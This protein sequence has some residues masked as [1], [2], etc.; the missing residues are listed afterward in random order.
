MFIF[1]KFSILFIAFAICECVDVLTN[2]NAQISLSSGPPS[3]GQLSF[4]HYSMPPGFNF[5]NGLGGHHGNPDEQ[6]GNHGEYQGGPG[7]PNINFLKNVSSEARME[8]L[9]IVKN[10]NLTKNDIETQLQA[11]SVQQSPEVQVNF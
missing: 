4:Q 3:S 11:W 2:A 1:Y 8:F 5:S 9:R 7:I 6:H 10:N